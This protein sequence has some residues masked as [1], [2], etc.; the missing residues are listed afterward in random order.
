MNYEDIRYTYPDPD[1][2]LRKYVKRHLRYRWFYKIIN[3]IKNE[4]RKMFKMF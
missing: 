4:T 2:K 1:G 3:N